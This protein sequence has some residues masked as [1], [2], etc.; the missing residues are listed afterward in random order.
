MK[1]RKLPMPER[2]MLAIGLLMVTLPQLLKI[3]IHIPDFLLGALVGGGLG[4]E[5][6]AFIKLKKI[7]DRD[8]AC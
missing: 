1:N 7:R 6:M 3:Y 4:L 5:I 8:M 2:L